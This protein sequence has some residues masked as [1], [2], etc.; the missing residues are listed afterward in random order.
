MQQLI[1]A[2]RST[3]TET[4]PSAVNLDWHEVQRVLNDMEPLL[5]AGNMQAN[6]MIKAHAQ[7]LRL[8]LGPTGA[9]FEHHI[10]HFLYP[11]ALDV[12]KRAR[13]EY[14]ILLAQ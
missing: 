7:M 5:M 9:E 1:V 14:P 2:I 8:A 12:L 3:L 10:E 6:H 11:E 13:N 4:M